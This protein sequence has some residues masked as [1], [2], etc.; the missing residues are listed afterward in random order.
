MDGHDVSAGT[1]DRQPRGFPPRPRREQFLDQCR[2]LGYEKSVNPRKLTPGEI[3]A[4]V[5]KIRTKYETYVTKYFKPRI[6]REAFEDRYIRALRNG[7]DVSSFLMAEISAIEELIKREEEKAATQPTKPDSEKPQ[8]FADKVVEENRKRILKYPDIPFHQDAS[9]E[10]RRL[11]GALT[12]L[13]RDR[14][15]QI[16]TALRDTM[17]SSS[18]SEMLSL[19]SQLRCLASAN[20]D[21]IPEFLIRLVAQLRKFPRIYALVE[22]DEKEYL[23]EAAFFLNDLFTALER[24]KR[25][26]TNLAEGARTIIDDNLAHVWQ[27]I[28]DFRV[29]EFK[30]KRP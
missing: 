10:T 25:V 1:F 30:R 4:A 11:L 6:L 15:Q 2:S 21:E 20:K 28:C 19:D 18:S 9:E 16:G 17:Y 23:L 12:D 3:T 26:Y 7:V 14:W 29:K 22:R 8:S 24:V 27:I 13:L 5:E